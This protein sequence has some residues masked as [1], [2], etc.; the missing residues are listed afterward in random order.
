MT[1][2]LYLKKAMIC[3]TKVIAIS[4]VPFAELGDEDFVIVPDEPGHTIHDVHRAL[5][6]DETIVIMEGED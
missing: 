5:S 2:R 3:G 6:N 4:G 1:K